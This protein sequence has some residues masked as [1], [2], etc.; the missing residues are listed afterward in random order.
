MIL[1][2]CGIVLACVSLWVF[3]LAFSGEGKLK[4]AGYLLVSWLCLLA[5]LYLILVKYNDANYPLPPWL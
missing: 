4:G 3:I 5:A 2:T 1:L